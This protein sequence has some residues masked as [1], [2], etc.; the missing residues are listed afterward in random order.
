M[1][2]SCRAR[3]LLR[4]RH[5]GRRARG[6]L[7]RRHE[8]S[9]D[10]SASSRHHLILIFISRTIT[11]ATQSIPHQSPNPGGPCCTRLHTHSYSLVLSSF[12]VLA[13]PARKHNTCTNISPFSS[14]VSRPCLTA[15]L[16]VSSPRSASGARNRSC[17]CAIRVPYRILVEHRLDRRTETRVGRQGLQQLDGMG[18]DGG[19]IVAL[20]Q[21]A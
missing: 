16:L 20:L 15:L 2:R 11:I 21:T 12:R 5:K 6:R 18:F 7:R 9:S 8:Y 3:G 19:R 10:L 4:R 14:H 13:S 1:A 17:S